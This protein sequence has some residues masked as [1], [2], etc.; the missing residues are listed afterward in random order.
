MVGSIVAIAVQVMPAALAPAYAGAASVSCL[1]A[2]GA[3]S[4]SAI[5]GSAGDPY[6]RTVPAPRTAEEQ[7]RY[8]ARDRRWVERCRPI[9]MQDRYGVARYHYAAAGCEFGVIGN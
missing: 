1:G 9:I 2:S 5:W 3:F 4:C 8:E 6:I 7:A